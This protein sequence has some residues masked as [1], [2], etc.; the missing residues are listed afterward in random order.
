MN[1]AQLKIIAYKN[2]CNNIYYI[3]IYIA[4]TLKASYI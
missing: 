3:Y 2:L 1:M 4:V